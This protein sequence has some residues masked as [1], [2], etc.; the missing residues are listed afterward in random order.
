MGAAAAV[1]ETAE[2][3]RER[4]LR[5]ICEVLGTVV[6]NSA[7]HGSRLDVS[8]ISQVMEKL[9]SQVEARWNVS[10]AEMAPELLFV[11]HETYT[12]AR[13]G[14][15]QAEVDA[16]RRVFG[17]AADRVVVANTKGF[18]G[19]PM[20]VGI[21]DVVAVKALETGIVPPVANIKERD[22]EFGILN[23]SR[24]GAY[25]VRYALRLG[26]GFGSQISMSLL[27]W[28]PNPD[29]MRRSPDALGYAYRVEDPAVWKG[30][31]ARVSGDPAAEVEV[32]SRT[33]RVVDRGLARTAAKPAETMAE[34]PVVVVEK[35]PAAVAAGPSP[36]GSG[37]GETAKATAASDGV[38]EKILSIV[39]EK[40]GYPREMLALDL[41][42]EADLG[43]DTVKQ[44]ETFA[45]IRAAY[46]IPRD[47]NLKLRDYPTLARAIQFVYDK[48][49]DLKAAPAPA[50]AAQPV[51]PPP[52]ATDGSDEVTEKILSIVAEKTGYPREML[53]LDLDME[54]DLGI[55]TV[56]QAETFAAIRAAYD[57][58]RDENL[59]LRDYPTLARAIQFVYDRRPDLET[60][61]AAAPIAEPAV[62]AAPPEPAN[63]PRRVP[64]PVLRPH[65]DVCKPTGVIL[66]P[67]SR[68]VVAFDQG[69]VGKSLA[70]KLAK[71]DVEVL[72][73]EDF[74]PAEEL[75]ARLRTWSAAGPVQGVY[76]LP[77]LDREGEIST[78][79]AAAWREALRVRAKLFYTTL[80]T[81]Y[82]PLG[83]PGAFVISGVR[84]G[85]RHGYD[86]AGAV[87]PLGGAVT[88]LTKSFKRERPGALVKAVDFPLD[89]KTA[90]L[91]DMLI[92]ETLKDPGAVEIGREGGRRWTIGLAETPAPTGPGLTFGRDS[93]FV[94]TGAAGSI[95][96]AIVEDL[97]AAS[98]GSFHLLDLAPEPDPNDPDV[99]K[100][101]SDKEGLKRDLFE[102]LKARGERA[103]P[104]LV[105]KELAKIE[106]AEAALA[107][108]R[109]IQ[110]AGGTARW[111]RLDL[112]DTGAVAA[113]IEEVRRTA[114]RVDVLVHAGGLEISRSLPD[115]KPEEFDLVFDVKADGW[116]NLMSAIGDMPLGAAVVFSSIAGRFGNSGQADY[117]AANDLLCKSISALRRTR[118]EAFGIATDWT[119]WGGIGMA[120]RGSIPTVMAAA[121]IDMLPPDVGIPVV[122]NELTA[123]TRGELVVA[124][125]LGMMA[126]EFD[127][128][129][130]LDVSDEALA[131]LKPTGVMVGRPS[132]FGIWSGLTVETTLDPAGQPFLDHHRIEGTPVLPGVMGVE[133]FAE[134]AALLF[135][136]LKV[137]DVEDVEFLIPF[138]FY[139]DEP[140]T[141]T[142]EAVYRADG[143]DVV[144]DC[145][146]VGRRTLPGQATP[147][148]TVHFKARVRLTARTAEEAEAVTARV[149]VPNG[150][151]VGAG[152]IYRI[153]FHGPAYQVM[154][155]AWRD[156]DAVAGMFAGAL[157]PNHRPEGMPTVM[158]PRLIELCF[159]TAGVGELGTR[160]RMAL[161][162]HVDRVRTLR[163][164][165]TPDVPLYALAE[166]AENGTVEARVVDGEGN[167]YVTLTGYRTVELPG[168]VE[169]ARLAPLRT[170]ME[171]GGRP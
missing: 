123:G 37:E 104:A 79:D 24:G 105:E 56:K 111:H 10:R 154:D 125:S 146:L 83:E 8:H 35:Q 142:I 92:E 30:W 31:L 114:G 3:A 69:G 42:M 57:I 116:F 21:E 68:V 78:M 74:P 131:G 117:S 25:P 113:A 82:E 166:P 54:A 9:V 128:T 19:H 62:E 98:G 108:V 112:R 164:P 61:P 170:A 55:D 96:S 76:W 103:T 70:G 88:G 38:E 34:A 137:A 86:E 6:A 64:V 44:A 121:G 156:G 167:V 85:G 134:A 99:A 127:E 39:A 139:R 84:L 147:Q 152:D 145:R 136:D 28:I 12:P 43:I 48:R 45:A 143:D 171:G 47:E 135:P 20:A 122:R 59:K 163:H 60:S 27:R 22:P 153:Y 71:M 157:P 53:D 81:L 73:I 155:R 72:A 130:G 77:A 115:K 89:R 50:P 168:G 107:A 13:G 2:A 58:P 65:L 133:G 101:T 140:R 4:G 162:L 165:E 66:G 15:A 7:F 51:A 159:Q 67:G 91:A 109:A 129:G 16:L 26:A 90:A 97:A 33:L 49:P 126:R 151:S 169:A 100:F 5:P 63:F 161:P 40:T 160:G 94:V 124:G 41:D 148:E 14:S 36:S 52:P 18:T 132:G 150:G 102:R 138:K 158:E 141:F 11:S 118:P 87:A 46:D 93:V 119:A 1:V 120:T 75:E 29:G 110:A 17:D 80:R 32:V 23:L 144:A 106:R 149:P 95:V